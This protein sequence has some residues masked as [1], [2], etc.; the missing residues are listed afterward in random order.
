MLTLAHTHTHK[1]TRALAHA[2]T[3]ART[4]TQ[5]R[6]RMHAHACTHTHIY[7]HTHTHTHT[8]QDNE[9]GRAKVR[10]NSCRK[11]MAHVSHILNNAQASIPH[12][13]QSSSNVSPHPGQDIFSS[14][15]LSL[16]F[17]L[18][19]WVNAF[20]PFCN[21]L[22]LLGLISILLYVFCS[23]HFGRLFPSFRFFKFAFQ[24]WSNWSGLFLSC[25]AFRSGTDFLCWTLEVDGSAISEV[26]VSMICG[27][28]ACS[29]PLFTLYV[30]VVLLH[31]NI[32]VIGKYPCET[33]KKT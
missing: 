2:Q 31:E 21:C 28:R 6:T 18:E 24:R 1:L 32:G 22:F 12:C 4:H 10:F 11:Y 14:S 17:E 15:L 27:L 26:V 19:G 8:G 7:T 30:S 9:S 13:T 3:L 29:L 23:V 33:I 20:W 16:S 5:T 25:A